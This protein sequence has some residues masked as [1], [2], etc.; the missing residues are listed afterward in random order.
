MISM[1]HIQNA[2]QYDPR[3]IVVEGDVRVGEIEVGQR[4]FLRRRKFI[5]DAITVGRESGLQKVIAPAQ[6]EVILKS[7]LPIPIPPEVLRYAQGQVVQ[8]L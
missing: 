1:L 4:V 6:C 5:I 3:R 7:V 8:A 2:T